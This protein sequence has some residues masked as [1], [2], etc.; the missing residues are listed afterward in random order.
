MTENSI[1]QAGQKPIKKYFFTMLNSEDDDL[2]PYEFR[3]LAHYRRVCGANGGSCTESTKTTASRS[4]MSHN[5]A[6]KARKFLKDNGYINAQEQDG[7]TWL[8]RCP[9]RMAQNIQRYQQP[10]PD[11]VGIEKEPLPDLVGVL[12]GEPLP[13]LVGKEGTIQYKEPSTLLDHI[14]Q[15]TQNPTNASNAPKSS[16]LDASKN[17]PVPSGKKAKTQDEWF[18]T[19]E[20]YV[21]QTGLGNKEHPNG[22]VLAHPVKGDLDKARMRLWKANNGHTLS[23]QLIQGGDLNRKARPTIIWRPDLKL[24]KEQRTERIPLFEAIG[25]CA[26]GVTAEESYL[27]GIRNEIAA[28]AKSFTRLLGREN[29]FYPACRDQKLVGMLRTCY[30]VWKRNNPD[31]KESPRSFMAILAQW[32]E[33]Y[34]DSIPVE[35]NAGI[36]F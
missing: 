33:L 8:V 29:E 9:D 27:P 18:I 36:P 25:E 15:E 24:P 10:R 19:E 32:N 20:W 23:Y 14:D 16:A 21:Y 6:R 30:T 34:P 5:T 11:Q 28:Y 17:A 35:E 22:V 2:G 13:D 3:L 26:I 31:L 1:P 7:D 4:H 12:G